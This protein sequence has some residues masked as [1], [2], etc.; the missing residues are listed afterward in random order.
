[1]TRMWWV[2]AFAGRTVGEP[3]FAGDDG[4]EYVVEVPDRGVGDDGWS[5]FQVGNPGILTPYPDA[6]GVVGWPEARGGREPQRGHL[7]FV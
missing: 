3:A 4:L 2:A 6:P 5:L 1:M 7:Q